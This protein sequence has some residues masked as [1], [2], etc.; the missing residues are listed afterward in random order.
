LRGKLIA[1]RDA[2]L[3]KPA[4]TIGR[5]NQVAHANAMIAGVDA[6]LAAQPRALVFPDGENHS[7]VDKDL[8]L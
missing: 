3:S 6:T 1:Q 5:R 4:N 2:A 8:F 7:S